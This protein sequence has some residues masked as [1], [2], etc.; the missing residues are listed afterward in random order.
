M[1]PIILPNPLLP[2]RSVEEIADDLRRRSR[3]YDEMHD[4]AVE[5]EVRYVKAEAEIVDLKA[6]LEIWAKH[7]QAANAEVAKFRSALLNLECGVHRA[8]CPKG[9]TCLDVR[10]EAL[11]PG[12][13]Y[14]DEYRERL[15]SGEDLCPP[16]RAKLVAGLA[17]AV[18]KEA[19][20]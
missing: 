9:T 16:C 7:F 20:P 1:T 4:R 15:R 12:S 13:K 14:G 8:S 5:A 3:L 17:D 6:R 11:V 19:P 18:I 10:A 2:Y